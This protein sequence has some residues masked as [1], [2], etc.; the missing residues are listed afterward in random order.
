V[1]DPTLPQKTKSGTNN[2]LLA[3]GALLGV[4]L[5]FCL[6]AFCCFR[7]K[8]AT[9]TVKCDDEP[10]QVREPEKYMRWKLECEETQRRP[11][12]SLAFSEADFTKYHTVAS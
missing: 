11:K 2:W 5:L 10:D 12:I 9:T 7:P 3:L 8:F 6:G 1:V 4:W